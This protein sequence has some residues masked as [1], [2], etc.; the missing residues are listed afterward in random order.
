MHY[1]I[2]HIYKQMLYFVH[3][4]YIF[5]FYATFTLYLGVYTLKKVLF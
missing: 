2:I 1:H 3:V 4:I 5:Y